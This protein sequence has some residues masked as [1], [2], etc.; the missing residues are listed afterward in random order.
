MLADIENPFLSACPCD[1]ALGAKFSFHLVKYNRQTAL[2]DPKQAVYLPFLVNKQFQ[3]FVW[4]VSYVV[5][6]LKFCFQSSLRMS[7]HPA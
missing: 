3:T 2:V 4:K 7:I 5:T 1:R 6:G